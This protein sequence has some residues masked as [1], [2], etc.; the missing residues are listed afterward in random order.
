[1]FM[2]AMWVFNSHSNPK[3]LVKS[4]QGLDSIELAITCL[5]P[6]HRDKILEARKTTLLD[7]RRRRHGSCHEAHTGQ[8]VASRKIPDWVCK[9]N[10]ISEM[11]DRSID[12]IYLPGVIATPTPSGVVTA[13]SSR[14]VPSTAS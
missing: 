13:S 4:V 1:M 10:S 6:L 2:V 5:L 7:C 14:L 8:T 12:A 11:R 9:F 3:L